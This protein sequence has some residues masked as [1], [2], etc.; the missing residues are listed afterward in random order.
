MTDNASKTNLTPNASSIAFWM[1]KELSP[2]KYAH[3]ESIDGC[4]D[5]A[6]EHYG[7]EEPKEEK[8]VVVAEVTRILNEFSKRIY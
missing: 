5:D 2:L 1:I 4:F 6:I 3:K 7:F 8:E